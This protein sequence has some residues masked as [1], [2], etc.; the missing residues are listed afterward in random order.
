[1]SQSWG[2][3]STSMPPGVVSSHREGHKTLQRWV[4]TGT[5]HCIPVN[6]PGEKDWKRNSTEAFLAG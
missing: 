5:G 2:V 3:G 6:R 1:M 4:R